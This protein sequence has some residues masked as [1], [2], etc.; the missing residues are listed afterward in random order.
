MFLERVKAQLSR[1]ATLQEAQAEVA[2]ALRGLME[3][4]GDGKHWLVRC[5]QIVDREVNGGKANGRMGQD[6][7]FKWL[8]SVRVALSHRLAADMVKIANAAGENREVTYADF[9]RMLGRVAASCGT[10]AAALAIR[11]RVWTR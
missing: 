11:R 7:L 3:R 5:F 9:L 4:G 1:A 8:L 2:A 6:A 10:E